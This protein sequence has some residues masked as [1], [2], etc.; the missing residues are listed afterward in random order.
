[1][2]KVL[3]V[4]QLL[5]RGGVEL[6]ALNFA[7][8]LSREKYAV[9]LLLVNPDEAQDEELEQEVKA[10]GFEIVEIPKNCN[11]YLKKYKF[12]SEL[13]SRE[14]FYAVH[15]HVLFF[16]GIVMLA[17]RKNGIKKRLCHSHLSR[18]N[19]KEGAAF[20]LY[21]QAMRILINTL[22]TD[23]L[24]CSHDAGCFLYGKREY[25]KNGVFIANA[26]D[27]E[28][29]AFNE[30]TRSRIRGEFSVWDDEILVGHI[31]TIYKIKNQVFLTEVLAEMQKR[32]AKVKL[33]LVGEE[34]ERS[35][36]E[37]KAK[38][39][40][41]LESIIFAGQ[42]SNVNEIL[43]A[44]DIMIFPS[45]FEGL[46]ISLIEAQS[47][48]L[49][50]LVSKAVTEDVKFNDNVEFMSLNENAQKWADKAF[51]MLKES[52]KEASTER[53]RESYDISVCA[54]RLDEILSS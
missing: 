19:R 32:N 33:L 37:E 11:S 52:R 25:E 14:N 50:C 9:T 29:Y 20:K 53:L 45:L 38:S 49:P 40:G 27:T 15:S 2:K 28:K 17:A 51:E 4:I 13:M 42:R 16:S 54:K 47:S 18:W 8:A 22:A 30:E 41:V 5:R 24:A 21:K 44:M 35:T 3:V 23:K 39:L 26:I 34:I 31:G 46:P 48:S 36:V 7:R 43:Q 12:I 10:Q 1:M 6:A